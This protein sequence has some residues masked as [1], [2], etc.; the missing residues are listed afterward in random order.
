M[1]SCVFYIFLFFVCFYNGIT[2]ADVFSAIY[3]IKELTEIENSLLTSLQTYIEARDK[4]EKPVQD[5]IK[6]WV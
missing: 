5:N 4:A 2:R 1:K 6:T 3:K